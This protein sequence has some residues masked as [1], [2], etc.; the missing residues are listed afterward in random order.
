MKE[1][2]IQDRTTYSFKH[3]PADADLV[4][5]FEQAANGNEIWYKFVD[6]ARKGTIAKV[7]DPDKVFTHYSGSSLYLASTIS[8]LLGNGKEQKVAVKPYH[9]NLVFLTG[10]TGGHVDFFQK[11]QPKGKVL[12]TSKPDLLGN[13]IGVGDWVIFSRGKWGKPGLG[14]LNRLSAAGNAWVMTPDRHGD[15]VEVQTEGASS[16][17]KVE[18]TPELHTAYQLCESLTMLRTKLVIGL[19]D[20]AY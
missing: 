11:G 17:I 18:M 1:V 6:G 12:E 9:N 10:Y 5:L 3:N 16:L 15:M 4:D 2:T 13:I 19:D 7:I 14:K 20:T 8:V